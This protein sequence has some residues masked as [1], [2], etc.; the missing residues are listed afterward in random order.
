MFSTFFT[1]HNHG[2]AWFYVYS[3]KPR[4][5]EV[6]SKDDDVS[7]DSSPEHRRLQRTPTPYY[8]D[9]PSMMALPDDNVTTGNR[10]SGEVEF[11][12]SDTDDADHDE[13]VVVCRNRRALNAATDDVINRGPVIELP[14]PRDPADDI[15][16]QVS[17]ECRIVTTN[18][19]NDNDDDVIRK[20]LSSVVDL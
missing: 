15:C 17:R 18:S 2:A 4:R 10:S 7:D 1:G 11:E 14:R 16:D 12:S 20:Q 5:Q 13:G 9:P 3:W 19:S 6:S 8:E